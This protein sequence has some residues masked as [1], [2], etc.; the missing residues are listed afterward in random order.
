MMLKLLGMGGA[1]ALLSLTA[2]TTPN[3]EAESPSEVEMPN[4]AVVA[5]EPETTA[6]EIT[7][8]V[9]LSDDGSTLVMAEFSLL[10]A[11]CMEGEG[12]LAISYVGEAGGDDQLVSCGTT[13]EGFDIDRETGFEG[14]NIVN[15][16][17]VDGTL[18]LSEGEY[19]RVQCLSNQT[20]LDPAPENPSDGH[21]V[22]NC[23]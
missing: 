19:T 3:P 18:Q 8:G 17:I 10:E 22:L 4:A 9:S 5:P 11:Y 7:E 21:M 16:A 20:S 23:L 1:I 15:P 6:E 2:C 12:K 14:V 13:F